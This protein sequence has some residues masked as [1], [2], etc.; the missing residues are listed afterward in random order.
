MYHIGEGDGKIILVVYVDDLFIT[1]RAESK[2]TW[3]K[4]KLKDEFDMTDLGYVKH[5]LGRE[6]HRLPHSLFLTQQQ[7]STKMLQEFGMLESRGEYTPLPA[8]TILLTNMDSPLVDPHLYCHIV[9]KLIFLTTTRPDLAYTV[10][11]VSRYMSQPQETHMAEV[12]HILRYIKH[13]IDY[14][15]LYQPSGEQVVHGFT[16]ADWAACPKT[17]RSTGGFCFTMAGSAII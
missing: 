7:Y 17:R 8:G 11:S 16:D 3:L 10:S 13:T 2:I 9:G 1:G 4:K 5:Y 6:F 15:L 14:S 12:K